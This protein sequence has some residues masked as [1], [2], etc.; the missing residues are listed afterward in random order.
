[1]RGTRARTNWCSTAKGKIDVEMAEAFL[2]D[3]FDS[4]EKK[5][6]QPNERSLCGHVD[7]IIRAA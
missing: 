6:Q 7:V 3:H 5:E 2:A 4:F 1:M